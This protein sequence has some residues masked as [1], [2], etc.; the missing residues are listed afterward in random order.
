MP[1]GS[2]FIRINS[3]DPDIQTIAENGIAITKN[4]YLFVYV[5]NESSG[6][7]VILIT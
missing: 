2:G 6:H 1:D 7:S 4:G 3:Y 5:S